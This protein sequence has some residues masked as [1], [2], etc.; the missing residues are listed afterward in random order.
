[1]GSPAL[2]GELHTRSVAAKGSPPVEGVLHLCTKIAPWNEIKQIRES[3]LFHAAMLCPY[4]DKFALN[5]LMSI[6]S[7][8]PSGNS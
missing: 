2:P 4:A 6:L 8:T 1:M 7:G 3:F 5:N